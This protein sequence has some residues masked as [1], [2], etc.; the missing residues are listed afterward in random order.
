MYN[1]RDVFGKLSRQP[2][3]ILSS[4]EEALKDLSIDNAAFS[5]NKIN[6][7]S[8]LK[9]EDMCARGGSADV[10]IGW[11]NTSSRKTGQMKVA[12]KFF[13]LYVSGGEKV[14]TV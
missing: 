8:R 2:S 3:V 11:L 13:C 6:L 1:L 4:L 12:V 5:L 10:Y 9:V 14:S 7:T